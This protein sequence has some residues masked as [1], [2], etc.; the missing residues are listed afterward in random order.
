MAV[1]EVIYVN[2][3]RYR[4]AVVILMALSLIVTIA[5]AYFGV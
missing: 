1:K 5:S 4:L 3:R 2:S